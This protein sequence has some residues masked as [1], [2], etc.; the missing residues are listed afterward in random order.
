[1]TKQVITVKPFGQM[2]GL[3]HKQGQGIDLRQFGT[4]E[5]TRASEVLWDSTKQKWYVEFRGGEDNILN[6]VKLTGKMFAH[7]GEICPFAINSDVMLFDEYDDAVRAEILY[8]N[9]ARMR[10]IID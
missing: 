2:A 7:A 4:A 6:G 3:Q 5:I 8:L 10:G 1:M 9:F